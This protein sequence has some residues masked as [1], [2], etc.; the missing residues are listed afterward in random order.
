MTGDSPLTPQQPRQ[1]T[2]FARYRNRI[3]FF[4]GL[5]G[6]V[7]ETVISALGRPTDLSLLTVF[8]GMMGLPAFL[9]TSTKPRDDD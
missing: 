9:P 1:R 7:A 2:W 4:S 3:L 8:V 5:A 6:V